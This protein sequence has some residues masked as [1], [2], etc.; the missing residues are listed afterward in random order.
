MAF[1]AYADHGRLHTADTVETVRE[2]LV[3]DYL[4]TRAE[5]DD[6]RQVLILARTR[7]QA[8][9]LNHAVRRHLLADSRPSE[10]AVPVPTDDGDVHFRVADEV[11]VMR[12]LHRAQLFKGTWATVTSV[13]LDGLVLTTATGRSAAL[14]RLTAGRVLDHGYALTIHKAQDVTV[15]RALLWADP[16]LNREAGYV[17]LFRARE[18]T[19]AYATPAFDP[20]DDLDCGAPSRFQG[21]S[22]RRAFSLVSDLEHSHQQYVALDNAPSR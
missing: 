19:H 20:L 22:G 10:A 7:A 18:A 2:Q 1:D 12:N 5:L 15:E 16:G 13:G 21:S 17:G 11:I 8:T 3:E 14:D 6:P 4:S 9:T